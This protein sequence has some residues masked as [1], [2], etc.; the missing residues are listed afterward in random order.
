MPWSTQVCFTNIRNK[1]S[2]E[3]VVGSERNRNVR[4][5]YSE[6]LLQLRIWPMENYNNRRSL[7]LP[8]YQLTL[9][10]RSTKELH[11]N[12]RAKNHTHLLQ[13]T[14]LP[15]GFCLYSHF[16]GFERTCV[17]GKGGESKHGR[18]LTFSYLK[19]IHYVKDLPANCK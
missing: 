14:L 16:I 18:A 5:S 9:I 8:F 15:P 6:V 4:L 17:K 2:C 3:D 19:Q 1:H 12:H 13:E 10:V 7:C 11:P